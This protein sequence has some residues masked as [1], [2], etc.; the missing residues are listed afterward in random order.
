M[1]MRLYSP[2]QEALDGKWTAPKLK[3]V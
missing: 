2:K 1:Y 3:R